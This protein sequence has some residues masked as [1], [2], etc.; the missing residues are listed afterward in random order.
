MLTTMTKKLPSATVL[1]NREFLLTDGGIENIYCSKGQAVEL[2]DK[3]GE[4]SN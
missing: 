3:V 1:N 4:S 2:I